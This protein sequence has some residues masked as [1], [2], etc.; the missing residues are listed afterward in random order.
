MIRRGGS[1]RKKVGGKVKLRIGLPQGRGGAVGL[2]DSVNPEW[3]GGNLCRPSISYS[4]GGR[5]GL[6][7]G[8]AARCMEGGE[9]RGGAQD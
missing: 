1:L 3:L 5:T 2:P 6:G 7:G 4:G 9:A 8:D